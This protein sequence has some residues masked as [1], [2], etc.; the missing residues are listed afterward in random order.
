MEGLSS[1]VRKA[2]YPVLFCLSVA[3]FIGGIVVLTIPLWSGW[4]NAQAQT[5]A[6]S[7]FA[8]AQATP[9]VQTDI[10]GRM[11]IPAIGVTT[12]VLQGLTF[13]PGPA[14]A[15]LKQGP[16]HVVDSADPG[17]DGNAVILGHLNVWGSVFLRLA[18]MR[19]GERIQ[20]ET[21]SDV[22]TFAVTGLQTIPQTD[23]AAV[24]PH[25]GPPTLQLVTCGGGWL[26]STRVV[27]NAKL[28]STTART[29]LQKV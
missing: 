18:R 13:Q 16:A 2:A 10:L 9:G 29:S 17:Q 27:V 15:L 26:D 11:T 28:V 7:A 20:F 19:P 14:G 21:V 3:A 23:V 1:A 22:Y 5:R 6:A 24:A 8:R 12:Y 4:L 25:G